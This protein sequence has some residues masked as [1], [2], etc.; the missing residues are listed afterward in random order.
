MPPS[1]ER[2][3]MA[4]V[5]LRSVRLAKGEERAFGQPELRKRAYTKL[6]EQPALGN[7]KAHEHRLGRRHVH[8]LGV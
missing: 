2:A 7:C 3:G 5:E 4:A 8:G 1:P 6:R